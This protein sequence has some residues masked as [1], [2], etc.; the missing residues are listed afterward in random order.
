GSH[1]SEAEPA[2]RP[3][4]V[5]SRGAS[6]RSPSGCLGDSLSTRIRRCPD[7]RHASHLPAR[8]ASLR[9]DHRMTALVAAHGVGIRFLFDGNRRLI[10]PTLAR[11]RKPRVEA[12]G[13]DDVTFIAQPG[14]SIALL[15]AS[16]AGKTTLLRTIAGIFAP[17]VGKIE[18]RGR[19]ASLLSTEA[20]L[21]PRLTGR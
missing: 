21:L 12:W 11:L 15:G 4:R 8:T 18:V 20:G 19:I 13:L 17:D 3:I 16:G 9:E 10:T 14:D 7:R 6:V 2:D 1:P 5:V